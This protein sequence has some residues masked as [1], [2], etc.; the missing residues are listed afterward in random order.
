VWGTITFAAFLVFLAL[1]L[2]AWHWNVWR[3]AD[4]GGL[5]EREQEFHRRQFRRR[6]QASGML[7]VIGLLIMGSLWIEETI[8][9]A[10]F[11]LGVLFALLWVVLLALADWWASRTFYGRDQA[12]QTAE[13]EILKAEIRKYESE[14]QNQRN[15]PS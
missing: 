4:H 9:Q 8:A 11:W 15:N 5:P 13:I 2:L 1:G 7:G 6:I 14:Q 12:L 3:Q 10:L